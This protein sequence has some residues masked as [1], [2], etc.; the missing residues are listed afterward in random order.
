VAFVAERWGKILHRCGV[1]KVVR[2]VAQT[3]ILGLA[4]FEFH[5]FLELLVPEVRV[6]VRRLLAFDD[7]LA[8]ARRQSLR[9]PA[10]KIN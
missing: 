5:D 3:L 4:L 9:V 1:R 2:K 8:Q 10:F 7:K 6:D